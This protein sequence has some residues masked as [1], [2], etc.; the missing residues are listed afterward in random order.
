[1]NGS[2]LYSWRPDVN[3]FTMI[4]RAPQAISF[5]SLMV[6]SLNTTK[7]LLASAEDNSSTVYEFTSV[8]NQSDFIPRYTNTFFYVWKT[9]AKDTAE[10]VFPLLDHTQFRGAAVCTRGQ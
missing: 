9:T 10:V 1:M 6:P 2:S 4:L 8:S 5:L 7:I 3:L